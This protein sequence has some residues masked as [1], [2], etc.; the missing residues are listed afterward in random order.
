MTWSIEVNLPHPLP[1][2]LKQDGVT[3]GD[4]EHRG[5]PG[6]RKQQLSVPGPQRG[7]EVGPEREASPATS[8]HRDAAP[9]LWPCQAH[10]SSWGI[11]A[12]VLP[13]AARVQAQAPRPQPPPRTQRAPGVCYMKE[14]SP[15]KMPR[16]SPLK[17]HSNGTAVPIC[18]NPH[19][20]Q[21]PL[22]TRRS[23]ENRLW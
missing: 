13:S 5:G 20:L 19:L 11:C 22:G 17:T 3:E 4:G 23:A 1:N 15:E 12:A 2:A 10:H 7:G 21:W 16:E 9:A 8:P 6:D 18:E 14:V